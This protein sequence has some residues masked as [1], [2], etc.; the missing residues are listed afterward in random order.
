[1]A[2]IGT[3]PQII[4]KGTKQDID[5]GGFH[6]EN[7][8]YIEDINAGFPTIEFA[9]KDNLFTLLRGGLF[10][11]EELI[12][13]EFASDKFTFTKKSFRIKSIGALGVEP[14]PAAA[15][16]VKLI[17]ID[18]NYDAILKNQK[19]VYF[20]AAEKKKPSDLLKK[21]LT[22]VG[23][24]AQT[25]FSINIDDTAPLKEY[26]FQNMFIPYSRD[27]MKVIRKLCNYAMAPDGTGAFTFYINRRGLYFVPLS[28]L[29]IPTTDTT[30]YLQITDFMENYG[31][32]DVKLSTFNAFSNFITGH[33]KK[34]M[35][36]NLLEKDYNS[37]FY[38]PNAKY[39]EHS[40]Y[41]DKAE[42]TSNVQTMPLSMQKSGSI[43]FS[44]DF[45]TGNVKVYFTPMDDPLM[46]KAFADRL[47]YSQMFNY[48]MEI[49]VDMMQIMPDFAIGEMV[50]VE[51]VTGDADRWVELN[52]GWLLKSF[53][54]IY[55]GD[56]CQLK[57]TRIGIASLPDKY[58]KQGE[59]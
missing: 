15:Q 44:K 30:P 19:S 11:D 9:L 37:I 22:Q 23:I 16:T 32:N 17:A 52:G 51:F 7:F 12:I 34:V 40:Q 50:N 36:F 54:Y 4:I 26:G 41:A 53:S 39:T 31:I 56:N 58:V 2:G 14:R 10:G 59:A 21:L 6:F 8:R 55:P 45:I 28:K 3:S 24:E 20:T 27:P 5:L 18:K 1:M 48:V 42:Q 13:E 33:E 29:F 25:N 43:P 49:D 35:G 46:L 47:H 38:K 57:L